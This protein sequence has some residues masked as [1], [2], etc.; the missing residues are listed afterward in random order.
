MDSCEVKVLWELWGGAVTWARD[1]PS[2]SSLRHKWW[3]PW[4]CILCG[5][6]SWALSVSVQELLRQGCVFQERQGWERPGWFNPQETA[7][8]SDEAWPWASHP[9]I[10]ASSSHPSQADPVFL[11]LV[12]IG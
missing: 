8:V 4:L 5:L 10:S 6:V 1:L 12:E 11:R 2:L 9:L 3:V 7:Q